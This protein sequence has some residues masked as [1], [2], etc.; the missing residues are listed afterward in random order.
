MNL[1]DILINSIHN[2]DYEIYHASFDK[3]HT[4]LLLNEMCR[5]NFDNEKVRLKNML[6]SSIID[7]NNLGDD[8]KNYFNIDF[9][10]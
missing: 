2:L 5:I 8:V 10:T 3:F 1:K 7:F 6:Y 4:N 9:Q